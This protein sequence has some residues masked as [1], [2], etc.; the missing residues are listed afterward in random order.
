MNRFVLS[1][2]RLLRKLLDFRARHITPILDFAVEHNGPKGASAYFKKQHELMHA[3]PNHYH[4]I[5]LSA[6][7]LSSEMTHALAKHA[8]FTNNKL[9]IDA[10]QVGIQQRIASLTDELVERPDS[11]PNVFKTYQMYRRDATHRLLTDIE[12]YVSNGHRLNVKLVR[13]AYLARDRRTGLLFDT[14]EDVDAAYDHAVEVLKAHEADLG[15]LVFATHN[16]ASFHKIKQ[17]TSEKCFHATLMGFDEPLT[18]TGPIR[19]MVYVPFGPYLQTIPYLVRRLR[20]NPSVVRKQ[21][22][23]EWLTRPHS[24]SRP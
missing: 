13:G 22:T 10:E 2:R 21:I 12:Y 7:D 19:R 3:F 8:A 1:E 18:W 17:L 23:S 20:E 24:N 15:E 6:L 16:E 14:K 11:P 4:A 5:K 9:M